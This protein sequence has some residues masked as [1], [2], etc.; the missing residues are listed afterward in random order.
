MKGYCKHDEACQENYCDSLGN[1]ILLPKKDNIQASNRSFHKKNVRSIKI[2][3]CTI[4]IR[5]TI[6]RG[7]CIQIMVW[8]KSV[9]TEIMS[10][11]LEFVKNELR[12]N[13]RLAVF[14]RI[15]TL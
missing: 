3:L 2:G 6:Q 15:C 1:M 10:V 4:T 12:G 14:M 11:V 9:L 5:A 8:N 7:D 13:N